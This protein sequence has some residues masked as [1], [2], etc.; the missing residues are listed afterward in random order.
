VCLF[1]TEPKMMATEFLFRPADGPLPLVVGLL[2]VVA[3]TVFVAVSWSRCF[4]RGVDDGDPYSIEPCP[5]PQCVRCRQYAAVQ[6]QAVRKL[7]WIIKEASSSAPSSLAILD[8]VAEGVS[9]CSGRH[10]GRKNRTA[11][12]SPALGQYPTVLL[13]PRL[14]TRPNVTEMHRQSCR[15]LED[16]ARSIRAEL[17]TSRRRNEDLEWTHNDT[18]SS[19]SSSSSTKNGR[20]NTTTAPEPWKVLHLMNQGRWVDDDNGRLGKLFPQTMSAVTALKNMNDDALLD[21]CIFGNVFFSRLTAGT[22]ID[23]HCGPTNVRHR[24]HL[25]IVPYNDNNDDDDDSTTTM[26]SPSSAAVPT[27]MTLD[28]R[29]EIMTWLPY[30][31]FVFDDSLPHGVTTTTGRGSNTNGNNHQQ[32]RIV[33][34]VDLWHPDLTA[35]ER[36]ALRQLYPNKNP[37]S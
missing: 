6:R 19:S 36:H 18:S 32:E 33:L 26:A 23:V 20:T 15:L 2:S 5:N 9:R 21:G 11:N 16:A 29:D 14:Y 22:T 35:A 30:R 4:R 27:T 10:N 13:V 7:P 12:M 37:L 3:G 24:L 1:E 28:V 34:I 31:A 17:E 25:T 8:R